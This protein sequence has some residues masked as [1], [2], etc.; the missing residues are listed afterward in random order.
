MPPRRPLL[1]QGLHAHTGEQ[2]PSAPLGNDTLPIAR[3]REEIEYAIQHHPFVI[4]ESPTGS[5]KST[6]IPQYLL[7][8]GAFTSIDHSQPRILAA[9]EVAKRIGYE[10]S[11]KWG[12]TGELLVACKT[13]EDTDD[14]DAPITVMTD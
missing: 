1:D 11:Q 8:L 5:G 9:Q 10:I 2:Y 7:Q 13:S 12:P 14:R 4:T 3:Y 6:Q